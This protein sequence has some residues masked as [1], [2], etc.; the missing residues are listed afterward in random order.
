[1]KNYIINA[2]GAK[3]EVTPKS[4]NSFTLEELQEHVGGY[5]EIIRLTNKCLMVVNEEGK[6]LNMPFN[7]EATDIARQHKAIYPNDMIVGNALV[8]Q[9]S[10]ID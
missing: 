6:L 10:M 8:A 7:S 9:E 3:T 1:M 5:I 4:G 2:N